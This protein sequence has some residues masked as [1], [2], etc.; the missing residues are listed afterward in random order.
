[1]SAAEGRV[2][3]VCLGPGGVPKHEVESAEVGALGLAGD[4]HRFHL[5][6][7]PDRAVCLFSRELAALLE[8]DG[9]RP[10]APGDFGENLCTEGLDLGALRI[11]DR[12]A[13]GDALVLEISDVRTPCKTLRGIDARFPD[14][15]VGRSGWLARV[16]TPGTVRRGDA[17]RRL[18]AAR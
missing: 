6:G 8:A 5:H 10:I 15:M 16:L 11:G 13:V 2:A 17:L 9:V 7:G 18:D 12:L 14:L 3:A 1:M 4:G